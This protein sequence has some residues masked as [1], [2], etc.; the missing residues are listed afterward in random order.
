MRQA[1]ER[2]DGARQRGNA[3]AQG[4]A[5]RPRRGGGAVSTVTTVVEKAELAQSY[6]V[7]AKISR[8]SFAVRLAC[9]GL[10]DRLHR[11]AG[12]AARNLPG[13]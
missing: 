12:A 7:Q 11:A 9:I 10:A 6:I 4:R 2:A 1:P 8:G 13:P 5:T 3:E